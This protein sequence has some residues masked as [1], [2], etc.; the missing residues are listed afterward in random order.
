MSYNAIFENVFTTLCNDPELVPGILGPRTG[1]NLR[2]YRSWP[3]LQSLLATYDPH[4][5]EGW[6]VVEDAE[7]L[8][9]VIGQQAH[10]NHE[11]VNLTIHVYG[12]QYSLTHDAMDV[13]DTYFHWGIP[14][15]RDLVFG[16]RIVLFTRRLSQY[17]AYAQDVK[18]A[19]KV[20]VYLMEM[21]R[22]TDLFP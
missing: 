1:T 10:S 20:L 9:R 14:Q 16:D 13:L 7:P 5:P 22:E 11:H 3:Q 2:L 19:E 12:T 6:L 15:Q 8:Q 18:L 4:P 21:V 17:D